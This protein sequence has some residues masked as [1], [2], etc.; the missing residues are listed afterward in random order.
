MNLI[1]SKLIGSVFQIILFT[2]V[3]LIWWLIT[4]RKDCTFFSWIGLKKCGK[5]NKPLLWVCGIS[6][7][8]SLISILMLYAVRDVDTAVSDFSGLGIKALPAI[9]IYAILN[10]ALPEEI[11]FRGFLLKRFSNR[12]GFTAGNIMQTSVFGLMHGILFF[13]A[14]GALKAILIYLFTGSVAWLI[15]Y[16]NEKKAGGSILPGWCIHSI[17]NILSGLCAACSVF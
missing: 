12:F 2:L 9:L 7:A 5:E 4:A 14:A 6:A 8:F 16:T 17:A 1:I 11:L 3:P 15:G 10:T 13:D